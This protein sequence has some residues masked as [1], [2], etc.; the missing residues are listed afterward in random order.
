MFNNV[1]GKLKT[2]AK[3]VAWIGM[4]ASCMLG[5][6]SIVLVRIGVGAF[7]PIGF[8]MGFLIM[9]I[10]FLISWLSSLGL[11]AFGELVE[12][13][14]IIA[15]KSDVT[16]VQTATSVN[17]ATRRSPKEA[18]AT[19]EQLRTNGLITEEEYQSKKIQL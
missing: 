9:V 17:Q 3:V 14:A 7:I 4:I 18:R 5:L 10:G 6:G 12:N 8:L 1:G 16:K 13:S 19:L 11:Y 2:L 15:G